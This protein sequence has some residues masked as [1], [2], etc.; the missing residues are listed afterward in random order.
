MVA[1]GSGHWE[2]HAPMALGEAWQ[3]PALA[4]RVFDA[5]LCV[6]EYVLQAGDPYERLI[7]FAEDL[8]GQAERAG[9][10]RGEAFSCHGARRRASD[11]RRAGDRARR[12][13][14][15]HP[16]QPRGRRGRSVRRSRASGS[17]RR[18][19]QLGDR[20]GARAQLEEAL[21]L[22]LAST[23]ARHLL[24]LV[25]APLVRHPGRPRRRRSPWSTAPSSC[26]TTP[27]AAT[28]ARWPTC[29]PPPR[30]VCAPATCSAPS[31][32]SQRA[33]QRRGAVADPRVVA[34]A[35]AR[36]AARSSAPATRRRGRDRVP[37][38][39]RG[40]QPPRARSSTPPVCGPRSPPDGRFREGRGATVSR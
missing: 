14:A 13:R 19:P 29:S 34:R 16:L 31:R 33:E 24:F 10:R 1:H 35:V 2:T 18:S 7:G 26:S 11:A 30:P 36:H 5:Y 38:R 12:A 17:A 39:A 28:S 6:T 3:L 32:S 37:P 15:G 4:G 23:L 27:P 9:A 8:R 21:E 20:T 22:S 25:H 40:L